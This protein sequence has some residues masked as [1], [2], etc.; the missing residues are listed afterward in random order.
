MRSVDSCGSV[1]R[2]VENLVFFQ[3]FRCGPG[4]IVRVKRTADDEG[5]VALGD[6]AIGS[7]PLAIETGQIM[8]VTPHAD[9]VAGIGNDHNIRLNIDG[10]VELLGRLLAAQDRLDALHG[11]NES[12]HIFCAHIN[13]AMNAHKSAKQ[14]MMADKGI[15]DRTNDLG[16]A[17]TEFGVEKILQIDDVIV[18]VGGAFVLHAMIGDDADNGAKFLESGKAVIQRHVEFERLG[19]VRRIF[20]SSSQYGFLDV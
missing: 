17:G 16:I 1:H 7:E 3:L 8:I 20:V 12:Y 13:K 10:Q 6:A 19:M 5:N 4:R 9:T 14:A 2:V 18:A 15:G 11:P